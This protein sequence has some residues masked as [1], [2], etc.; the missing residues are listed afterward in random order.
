[1][2]KGGLNELMKTAFTGVDKML[3]CKKFPMNIRAL[4]F[5]VH[6]LLC[7]TIDDIDEGLE[8]IKSDSEDRRKLC[9]SL[10]KCIHPLMV[11]SHAYNMLVNIYTGQ[12]AG[13][14]V[15]VN[16]ALEIGTGEMNN[17]QA[18]IP[19][20]FRARLST[21]MVT[22]AEETKR[23]AKNAV[24]QN[25]NTLFSQVLY[26]LRNNSLGFSTIFDYK[27]SPA[28]TSLFKDTGEA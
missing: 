26:V 19:E 13:E 25:Y 21:K 18:S 11:E 28:L 12:E 10:G 4:R 22:M 5:V 15:N 1:M 14:N 24:F 20:G 8:R 17:F 16:K 6:K 2:S 23:K 27:L 3:L 7:G 9:S